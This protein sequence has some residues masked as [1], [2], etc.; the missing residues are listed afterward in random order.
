V[1]EPPPPERA[2]NLRREAIAGLTRTYLNEAGR[3]GFEPEEVR[4]AVEALINKWRET[5]EPPALDED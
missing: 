1:L 5:G 4:E 3:M 2:A